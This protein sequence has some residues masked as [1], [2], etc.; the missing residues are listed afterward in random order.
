MLPSFQFAF[1]AVSHDAAAAS[2]TQVEVVRS[3]RM[4][5]LAFRARAGRVKMGML[6]MRKEREIGKPI[7]SFH[8]IDVMDM[9]KWFQWSS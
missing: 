2:A 4:S 3:K 7:V 9:L 8:A 6:G 5:T 1:P